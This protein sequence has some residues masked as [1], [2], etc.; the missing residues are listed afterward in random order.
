VVGV[1]GIAWCVVFV[2]CCCELDKGLCGGG[3]VVGGDS[4]GS[5]W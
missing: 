5:N 1:V 2:V 4:H 3:E